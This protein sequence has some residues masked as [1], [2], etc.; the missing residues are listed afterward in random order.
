MNSILQ[1]TLGVVT[2]MGGFVDIGE[3][4]F[5]VQAG[6]KFGYSLLWAILLGTVGIILFSEQAGR[7]TAV[8]GKSLFTH[9]KNDYPKPLML[10][11]LCMTSILNILTCAAEVGGIALAVGLLT[12]F[13]FFPCLTL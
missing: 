3:L 12:G 4:V 1:I 7:I 5:S 6:V 11:L 13:S 8:T 2:A 9:M 10:F